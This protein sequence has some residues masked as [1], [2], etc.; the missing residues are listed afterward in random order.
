MNGRWTIGGSQTLSSTNFPNFN[1]RKRS[2]CP[3]GTCSSS[4]KRG[5]LYTLVGSTGKDWCGCRLV[6]VYH[7]SK[8]KE[9]GEASPQ[10]KKCTSSISL[11]VMFHVKEAVYAY[12]K[13][14]SEMSSAA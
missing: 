11:P 5:A 3:K 4:G 1:F 9:G 8:L 12:D 13:D 10:E 7:S 2:M 14:K 6:H